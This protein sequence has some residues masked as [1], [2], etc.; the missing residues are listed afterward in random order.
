MSDIDKQKEQEREELLEEVKD[1]L[2]DDL[3]SSTVILE[4]SETG[5]EF[6]FF[7]LD[8]FEFENEIYAFL[9]NIEEEPE[10]IF[11]KVINEADGSMNFQSI[12]GDE[13][14]RVSAYF[15]SLEEDMEEDLF[16][17]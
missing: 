14:E 16:E 8:D 17:E 2:G 7:M 13:F 1:L 10:A 12:T 5:E 3:E 11:A 9:L 6:T 15:E 4:D